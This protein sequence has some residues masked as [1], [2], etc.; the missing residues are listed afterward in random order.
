MIHFAFGFEPGLFQ[1]QLQRHA[2]VLHAMD[3]AVGVLAA[4]ELGA[5]PLHAGIGGAFEKINSVDARQPLEVFE[6]EDQRLVDQPMQH[7]PVVVRIDFGDAAVVAL[8][9]QTVRRDDSVKR[10]AAA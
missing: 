5:A 3:H 6:R 4:V 9:A 2:G 10:R 1:Q 7:Q 8:E